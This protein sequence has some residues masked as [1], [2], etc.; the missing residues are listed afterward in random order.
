MNWISAGV[1]FALM[2]VFLIVEA[3]CP[4][5]LVSVWFAAGAL[6]ASIVGV[7]GGEI[8]LQVFLFAVV[9]CGLLIGLLPFTKKVLN[10]QHT[11]TN[12]DSVLD[13]VGTVTGKIDNLT[14]AGQV[15]IG[16]MTWSARSTSGQI[17]EEGSTVKV[18]KIEGVKVF[19]SVVTAP[20]QTV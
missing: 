5:H 19:V 6:V 12:L 11:P 3:A 14:N 8:W 20:A 17:I 15:R 4:I 9:S 7:L 2:L 16:G 18:D 10:P 13:S 1:W